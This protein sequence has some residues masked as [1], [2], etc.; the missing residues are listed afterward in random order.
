MQKKVSCLLFMGT[1]LFSF[2]L[3]AAS[4]FASGK[5][6]L[7]TYK[8]VRVGWKHVWIGTAPFCKGNGKDCKKRGGVHIR[9][10]K[11]GSG[12]RCMSGKKVLCKIPTY[13]KTRNY[14]TKRTGF[15]YKWFGTAPF[16]STSSDDCKRWG[17]RA[18]VYDKVGGG[19]RCSSGQKVLCHRSANSQA[20]RC[21]WIGTAP[22]CTGSPYDCPKK[23]LIYRKSNRAG[24]GKKCQ[25]GKKVYCCK[26]PKYNIPRGDWMG[27]YYHMLKN[28]KL[29][30]LT[31]PATHDSGCYQFTGF[32]KLA[33]SIAKTQHLDIYKQLIHGIRYFD[34]R[35]RWSYDKAFYIHHGGTIGPKFSRVLY[36]IKKFLLRKDRRELIILN[37]S[38]FKTGGKDLKLGRF[39]HLVRSYLGPYIYKGKSTLGQT[40]LSSILSVGSK[41]IILSDKKLSNLK[42]YSTKS[43]YD[44]YSNTTDFRYM[45]KDQTKKLNNHKSTDQLFLL[46]WTL[47]PQSRFSIEVSKYFPVNLA[48]LANPHLENYADYICESLGKRPNL[49]Y[50][51]FFRSAN[52][53]PIAWRMNKMTGQCKKLK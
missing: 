10:S 31:L 22:F 33:T 49:L 1:L 2:Y 6:W 47:T 36:D 5:I 19:K 52:V 39:A 51:D 3:S 29:I 13:K 35:P 32:S 9:S 20:A 41:V 12:K 30:E 40:K 23:D 4:S 8:K 15:Q 48:K 24:D 21:S 42:Y 18:V 53:V 27:R 11:R 28:K 46:S 16:C 38:H 37:F 26:R 14:I 25:T 43:V 50:V 17:G 7:S 45:K 34:L 44:N